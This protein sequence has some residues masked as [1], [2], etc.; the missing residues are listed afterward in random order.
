MSPR[1][2]LVLVLLTLAT[3]PGRCEN[4]NPFAPSDGAPVPVP[5]RQAGPV[6]PAPPPEPPVA[7]GPP[8]LSVA[9][10]LGHGPPIGTTAEQFAASGAPSDTVFLQGEPIDVTFTVTNKG[11]EYYR[12]FGTNADQSNPYDKFGCEVLDAAGR[13]LRDPRLL[14]PG[15]GGEYVGNYVYLAPGQSFT[16]H[17]YLNQWVAPLAPGAYRVVGVYRPEPFSQRVPGTRSG[18]AEI[19]IR[20]QSDQQLTA[21]AAALWREVMSRQLDVEPAISPSGTITGP[22]PNRQEMAILAAQEQAMQYLVFTGNHR[23]VQYTVQALYFVT[24]NTRFRAYEGL[25][26]YA[27]R[28]EELVGVLLEA[29]RVHGP[30]SEGLEE[31][32][33]GLHVPDSMTF[34]PVLRGLSLPNPHRR[35]AAA[36]LLGYYRDQGDAALLPLLAALNDSDPGVRRAVVYGL[37]PYKDPRALAGLLSA[38]H[39]SDEDVRWAAVDGL[40]NRGDAAVPRLR[41]IL[42]D[43][44]RPADQALYSLQ[45]IGTPA[46]LDAL[47]DGLVSTD[48]RIALHAAAIRFIFGDHT[49][50]EYLAEAIESRLSARAFVF[51]PGSPNPFVPATPEQARR[52]VGYDTIMNWLKNALDARRLPWPQGTG[53]DPQLWIKWLRAQLKPAPAPAPSP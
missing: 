32:F 23:A 46:A 45:E 14:A 22:S 33:M 40:G 31:F 21:R 39:D 41:E 13:W 34:G 51:N 53:S 8:N 19:V 29:V 28:R 2:P 42:H 6:P 36:A 3:V 43:G 1:F 20:A 30:P 38:T 9:I 4:R 12:Y 17:Y 18:L 35:A 10:V 26:Y 37:R 52:W 49:Q 25:W 48:Q 11:P 50:G 5:Y 15:W 44:L 16:K 47:F 27:L 7:K 24:G